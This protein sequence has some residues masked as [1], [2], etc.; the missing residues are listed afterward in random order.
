MTSARCSLFMDSTWDDQD[1]REMNQ[2]EVGP[3]WRLLR[4]IKEG[5]SSSEKLFVARPG[6]RGFPG[7]Y[8]GTRGHLS[9]VLVESNSAWCRVALR[10]EKHEQVTA[11]GTAEA[12]S[13]PSLVTGTQTVTWQPAS[14]WPVHS[15]WYF[16]SNPLNAQALILLALE[17]LFFFFSV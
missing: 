13:L 14:H 6:H 3:G 7:G 10:V 16:P 11:D 8:V 2:Q 12:L 9:C 15:G 4:I 1:W 17:W 5:T